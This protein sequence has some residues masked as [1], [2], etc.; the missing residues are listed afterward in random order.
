MNCG[1]GVVQNIFIVTSG[2]GGVGKSTIACRL[3]IG[4]AKQNLKVGLL[5]L[6]LCGPSIP[7]IM[8]LCDANVLLISLRPLFSSGSAVFRGL[9]TRCGGQDGKKCFRYVNCLSGV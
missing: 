3:A 7:R 5:D 9:A 1:I 6:D 4:L 2:K 8:G